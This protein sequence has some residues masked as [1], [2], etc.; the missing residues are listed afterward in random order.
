[1]TL[2]AGTS[3]TPATADQGNINLGGPVIGGTLNITAT[4]K[5]QVIALARQDAI[6]TSK[7]FQGILVALRN[8]TV[9][10]Q[11]VG[12][13]VVIGDSVDANGLGPD[14]IL[15]SQNLSDNGGAAQ[16]TLGTSVATSTSSQAAAQQSSQQAAQIATTVNSDLSDKK[17]KPKIKVGRVTVILSSAAP[18]QK[19]PTFANSTTAVPV[20]PAKSS[21]LVATTR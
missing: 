21:G 7:E 2:T 20:L 15:L 13:T 1:M 8:A 16:S 5:S 11:S 3:G 6:I 19:E 9:T 17:E 14:A 12:P 18:L 4:G 10:A